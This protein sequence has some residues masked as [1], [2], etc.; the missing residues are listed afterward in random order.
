MSGLLR[1]GR[2]SYSSLIVEIIGYKRFIGGGGV[3]LID[4]ISNRL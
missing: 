2:E 3:Y 1:D 4:L